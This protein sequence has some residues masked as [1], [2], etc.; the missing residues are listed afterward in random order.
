MGNYG[1]VC[2][3]SSDS[4]A[5]AIVSGMP[6]GRFMA[7]AKHLHPHVPGFAFDFNS[8]DNHYQFTKTF[9]IVALPQKFINNE[10]IAFRSLTI[11]KGYF[12]SLWE[13]RIRQ[14]MN[15]NTDYF[16]MN[17]ILPFLL[18]Q[19]NKCDPDNNQYTRAIVEWADIQECSPESAYQELKLRY[20]GHGL[21][22]LRS[23][24]HYTKY[25]RRIA[26]GK[27]AEEV[28]EEFDNGVK[29]LLYNAQL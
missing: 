4:H 3:A 16:G 28:K 19:L 10:W 6:N 14:N 11:K 15:K 18:D 8:V 23:H 13:L 5:H 22:N 9:D 7:M 29:D 2:T 26:A 17:S 27:T 24:A 20:E 21:V 12:L 1:I 25:A